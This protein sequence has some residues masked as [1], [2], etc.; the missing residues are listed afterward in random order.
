MVF[1]RGGGG[2]RGRPH[3]ELVRGQRLR[4]E[5][6]RHVLDLRFGLNLAPLALVVLRLLLPLRSQPRSAQAGHV[7]L[8]GEHAR[9]GSLHIRRHG[10]RAGSAGALRGRRTGGG[11][12]ALKMRGWRSQDRCAKRGWTLRFF[13]EAIRRAPSAFPRGVRKSCTLS[14]SGGRK[15]RAGSSA[16]EGQVQRRASQRV[17]R[18]ENMS[19]R[20][21]GRFVSG[22]GPVTTLI[23]GAGSRGKVGARGRLRA[24]SPARSARSR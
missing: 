10:R 15:R 18:T 22:S 24:P 19:P 6:G 7:S 4:G 13:A 16:Q 8:D 21:V 3:L 1:G 14:L 2:A 11:R 12:E 20:P 17:K 5:L 23:I 9:I